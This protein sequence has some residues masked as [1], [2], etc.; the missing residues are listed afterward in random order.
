MSTEPFIGEI[1][2]LAFQFAPR[3]YM[4][5]AG[6]IMSIASNTALFSLLGTTY[7]GNGVQT[8]G[9]PDL[10]GRMPINQ[11]TGPGLP[12]YALGQV[13]GTT[14]VTLLSSNLPPHAH[15]AQGI[16]VNI[17]VSA[18]SGDTDVPNGAFLAQ[19]TGDFYS[20]VSTPGNNYGAL[21][22]S[23]QTGIAGS[24]LPV[25]IMNPYLVVNYSIAIY[26]IFPSRN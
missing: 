1:K 24:G 14:S 4:D 13:S 12:S 19:A 9:L 23:G 3:S 5:C 11:G 15:P 7:G 2:I 22:V 20:S 10:R 25:S 6:Q 21:A 17:P 26:G 18:G 8:F 16:N